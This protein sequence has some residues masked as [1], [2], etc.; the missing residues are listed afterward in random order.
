M[1]RGYEMKIGYL[2]IEVKNDKETPLENAEVF[3]YLGKNTNHDSFY[4]TT[5]NQNGK[6]SAIPLNTPPLYES[7]NINSKNPYESYSI[8]VVLKNFQT[9]E[10]WNIQIFPNSSSI[11][12][13]TLQQSNTTSSNITILD[14]HKLQLG[15]EN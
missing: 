2:T 13:V 1:E 7:Y 11:L 12:P 6:T 15:K 4:K 9:E 10:I 3:V 5:T 8:K 14:E